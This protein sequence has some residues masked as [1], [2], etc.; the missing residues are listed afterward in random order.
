MVLAGPSAWTSRVTA[1]Q[2][3]AEVLASGEACQAFSRLATKGGV[4]L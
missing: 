1:Q 4:G 2:T 3:L